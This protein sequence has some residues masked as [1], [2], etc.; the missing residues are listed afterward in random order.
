MLITPKSTKVMGDKFRLC[1]VR[2]FF[3]LNNN[4][5]QRIKY[6]NSR[7]FPSI[8]KVH[9]TA[10]TKPITLILTKPKH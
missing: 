2:K 4:K 9:F 7:K 10:R 3:N 5:V 6:G 8:S 1:Y